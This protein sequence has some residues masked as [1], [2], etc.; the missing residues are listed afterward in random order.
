MKNNPYKRKKKS[1]KEEKK[2]RENKTNP[3]ERRVAFG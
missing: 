2:T 1:V 3:G